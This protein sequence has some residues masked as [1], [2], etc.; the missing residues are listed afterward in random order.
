MDDRIK[1]VNSNENLNGK[2]VLYWMQESQRTRYNFGLKRAIRISNLKKQPLYVVFN[3]MKSY[4]EAQKRHFDFM[5][6]GLK[7]VRE[8][9]AKKKIKFILLEGDFQKNILKISEK[10]SV[11]IWDKSYL[12]FQI[13]IKEKIL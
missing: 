12:K 9:L 1:K 4:P 7:N 13:S 6:Q 3:L 5:L 2:Y 11:M 10:A 8:N